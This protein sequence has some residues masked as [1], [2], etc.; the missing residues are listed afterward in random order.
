MVDEELVKLF[1]PTLKR[2]KTILFFLIVVIN[3][4]IWIDSNIELNTCARTLVQNNDV[5]FL[6][7]QINNIQKYYSVSLCVIYV[8]IY[9]Y[10]KAEASTRSCHVRKQ[11]YLKK[12]HVYRFKFKNLHGTLFQHS[13]KFN[14]P[15]YGV[16]KPL[17]CSHLFCKSKPVW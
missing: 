3:G 11:G 17:C 15:S 5:Y 6:S 13:K 10:I 1:N 12:W 4:L 14:F 2:R 9:I 16:W 8:Y 7:F